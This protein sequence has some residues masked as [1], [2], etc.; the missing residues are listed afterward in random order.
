MDHLGQAT[1]V[2]GMGR[3]GTSILANLLHESGVSMYEHAIAPGSINPR[4]FAEETLVVAF[5]QDLKRRFY[6]RFEE[7]PDYDNPLIDEV[8]PFK[9]DREIADNAATLVFRLQRPGLWGWKDPRTVLFIDLWLELLPTV[10]MVIPLRHPVELFASYLLRLPNQRL[11]LRADQVFRSYAAYHAKIAQVVNRHRD[12]CYV[13]YAQ[14]A[15]Q[16]LNMFRDS[17]Q[18]FLGSKLRLQE[19]SGGIHLE[20]FTDL[21]IGAAEH[22]SFAKFFPASAAWFDRLND[23]ADIPFA[24]NSRAGS[25]SE[26]TAFN[27]LADFLETDKAGADC[28]ALFFRMVAPSFSGYAAYQRA[29]LEELYR[30]IAWFEQQ[31]HSKDREIEQLKSVVE[32]QKV[33]TAELESVKEY[34]VGQL[35]QHAQALRKQEQ[36]IQELESVKENM[37]AQLEEHPQATNQQR[38][39]IKDSEGRNPALWTL[40]GAFRFL[41]R[42]R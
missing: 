36:Y 8:L 30:T 40:R 3:S 10:R 2:L 26:L 25:R 1:I 16:N 7:D 27:R 42:L 32:G 29:H 4:G 15:Y 17:L 41:F 31:S 5:H 22:E 13:F 21:G 12:Q 19:A 18:D 9:W 24:G 14:S 39:H 35:A 6:S 33:Y 38:L 37:S 34:F 23:Q 20:E 11:M 28:A